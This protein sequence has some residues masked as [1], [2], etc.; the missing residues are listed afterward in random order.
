METRLPFSPSQGQEAN[1]FREF[2]CWVKGVGCTYEQPSQYGNREA[3]LSAKLPTWLLPDPLGSV[4]FTLCVISIK[5][6]FS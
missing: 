1:V 2:L 4:P 6:L 5:T 3:R